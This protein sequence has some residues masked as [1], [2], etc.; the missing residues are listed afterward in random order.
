MR[1]RVTAGFLG[2]RRDLPVMRSGGL[3]LGL[4]VSTSA[5]NAVLLDAVGNPVERVHVPRSVAGRERLAADWVDASISSIAALGSL[6]ERILA[7]GLSRLT[8]TRVCG[9][10]P[11]G[12]TTMMWG[13]PPRR[14]SR[15]ADASVTGS[16]TSSSPRLLAWFGQVAGAF[17]R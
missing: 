15:W 5:V 2:R 6:S 9:L 1:V 14:R 11:V 17:R 3:W 8:P 12:R 10:D 7:V 16:Q 4:D 13:R